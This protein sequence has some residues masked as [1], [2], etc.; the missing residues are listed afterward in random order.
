MDKSHIKIVPEYVDM[1]IINLIMIRNS[2][3]IFTG[4]DKL[5]CDMLDKIAESI[6]EVIEYIG[7]LNPSGNF[8]EEV[9]ELN[10]AGTKET[11]KQFIRNYKLDRISD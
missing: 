5:E 7:V 1:L 6:N 3:D 11:I 4:D 2:A 10:H 8:S 9:H